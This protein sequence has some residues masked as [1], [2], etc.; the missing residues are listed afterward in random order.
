[1]IMV[2]SGIIHDLKS[3]LPEVSWRSHR[4]DRG[5]LLIRQ[6]DSPLSLFGLEAGRVDLKRWT[7]GGSA[8]RLH[9]AGAGETLAE[10]SLFSDS[11]H[12]DAVVRADGC[13]TAFSMQAVRQACDRSPD[14]AFAL[15]RHLSTGLRD[16]RRIIEL[17]SIHPLPDRLLA[18]LAECA[19][20]RGELP[21]GLL[22]KDIAQEIGAT[23][24]AT[25]RAAGALVKAGTL[26][27]LDRGRYRLTAA[28]KAK[29]G[30]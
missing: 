25:Y 1:M 28:K 15:L 17:R 23:P 20:D 29:T 27:R 14:L 2:M 7:A 26:L 21:P 22:M 18:R 9:S 13:A 5:A 30:Y 16:A 3:M 19:D 12:C 4:L 24:E 6:G 11:Y 10:A 8:G